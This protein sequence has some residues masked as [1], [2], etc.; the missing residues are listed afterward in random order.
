MG[1]MDQNPYESPKEAPPDVSAY[2]EPSVLADTFWLWFWGF[3]AF[4]IIVGVIFL[5]D[6]TQEALF[7]FS[8]LFH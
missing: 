3:A 2:R 5:A 4:P 6:K 8:S 1:G 7:W